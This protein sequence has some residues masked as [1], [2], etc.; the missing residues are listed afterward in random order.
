[1]VSLQIGPLVKKEFEP[2]A[3][4]FFYQFET[5]QYKALFLT[6][7]GR[8]GKTKKAHV[9]SDLNESHFAEM[10]EYLKSKFPDRCLN[11]LSQ[12]EALNKMNVTNPNKWGP[13]F[14]FFLLSIIMS[15]FF[16]PYLRHYF[17][18][19]HVKVNIKEF[20]SDPKIGTRNITI[21]GFP[22]DVGVKE[23]ITS[24]KHGST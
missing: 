2:S 24:T 21:S 22:L 5:S 20:L 11:H 3:L 17:D 13:V 7:T 10:M 14:V 6:Y 18:S 19:G 9:Y 4:Q 16:Y 23:T 1:M 8:D 12:Q 15:V